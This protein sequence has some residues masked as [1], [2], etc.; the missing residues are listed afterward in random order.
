MADL[1][2]RNINETAK[3][4]LAKRAERNGRSQ[5]AEARLILESTLA[6]EERSWVS[7][8]RRAAL[9]AEGIDIPKPIRHPARSV[10]VEGWL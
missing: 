5:Q 4:T 9:R 1:L 10:D 3:A 7:I 2:I 8:L 6:S